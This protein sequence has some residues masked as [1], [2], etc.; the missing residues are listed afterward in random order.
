MFHSYYLISL[1]ILIPLIL[2]ACSEKITNIGDQTIELK[3]NTSVNGLTETSQATIF[4]L[5]VTGTGIHVPIEVPLIYENG[6][7]TGI[8]IVPAGPKRTFRIRAFDTAGTL[9]YS[10]QTTVDI[11]TDSTMNLKIDLLPKVPM[12][13]IS[14]MYI[15]APQGPLLAIK[16]KVFHLN[17][18]NT[19]EGFLDNVGLLS[20][21]I[22]YEENVVFNPELAKDARLTWWNTDFNIYFKVEHLKPTDPIVDANGYAD[23]FTVYYQT[24]YLES[25]PVETFRFSPSVSSLI[26]R[27]GNVMPTNDIYT[28][29]GLAELYQ[30][31]LRRMAYYH[32]GWG[33]GSE[34][35]NWVED[36][37]G[38]S[39]H[40]ISSGTYFD[41]GVMGDARIF[42]GVDDYIQIPHNNILNMEKALTLSFWLDIDHAAITATTFP[43]ITKRN[44]NGAINYQIMIEDVSN[45]DG[46]IS[47][48]FRYGD[49]IYH[50]YR[51]DVPDVTLYW[52]RHFVFSFEFG[53]PASAQLVANLQA[54][55]TN[56]QI[57]YGEWTIGSGLAPTP[58]T[59][60][61]LLIGQD[62]TSNPG[63]Y[64]GGVDEVEIFDVAFDLDFIKY[65]YMPR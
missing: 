21:L 3:I 34:D 12:I 44:Q 27:F 20:Q 47:I 32:M 2:A 40:G 16:V 59:S 17:D 15:L 22:L 43:V 4:I 50:T 53:N 38:N 28:E 36:R 58:T 14:P 52:F 56:Y 60:G 25:Y 30:Y 46:I 5:T 9:M 41:Y 23:L 49:S 48:L 18:L 11:E 45:D 29:D 19:I 26:D 39:Q 31:Q 64:K 24:Y 55:G 57:Y 62:N 10:G 35:V 63:Y 6:F 33:T 51:V 13:K 8:I 54:E 65:I 42:D 1:L 7:L 37:S 61:A